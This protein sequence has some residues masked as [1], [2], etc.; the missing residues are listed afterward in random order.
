MYKAGPKTRFSIIEVFKP[1][2]KVTFN[3][4]SAIWIAHSSSFFPLL[5]KLL[6]SIDNNAC[7][8]CFHGST[9]TASVTI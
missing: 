9:A 1:H 2:E 3:Q 6:F 5:G 7:R 4:N 8:N